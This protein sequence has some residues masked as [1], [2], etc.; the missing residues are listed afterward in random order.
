MNFTERSPLEQ[1]FAQVFADDVQPTLNEFEFERKAVLKKTYL[2]LAAIF[3]LAVAAVGLAYVI[4]QDRYVV[5][6]VLLSAIFG[7]AAMVASWGQAGGTWGA[8]IKDVV[9]PAICTH[10]GD[11]TYT[12]GGSAFSLHTMKDLRLLPKHDKA[13]LRSLL[14][15]THNGTGFEMVHATLT[16]TYTDHNDRRRTTTDF[17]GLLFRIDLPERAPG[18]IALMRDRGAIGNKLA[19]KLAFGSTRSLPKVTFDHAAF[20]A[21]F[22]VYA[23]E[24]DAAKTFLPDPMLDALLQIGDAHGQ[25]LGAKSYVAGFQGHSFYMALQRQGSFMKMGRLTEPVD[26]IEDDLHGIFDDIALGHQIIDRLT[27]AGA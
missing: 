17:Q 22:E 7:G 25:G 1:G 26:E 27:L 23:D 4:W 20:E 11:L 3:L 12:A 18:R 5:P 10:V 15:G 16:S 9:M 2:T 13:A 8:K 19:E 6:A 21:A 24:P 14:Q